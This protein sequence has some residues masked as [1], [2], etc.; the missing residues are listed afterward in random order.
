MLAKRP[1]W[2]VTI[3]LATLLL[4]LSSMAIFSSNA[5]AVSAVTPITNYTGP[6]LRLPWAS[7]S[8]GISQSYNCNPPDGDHTTGT[9]DQFALDFAFGSG[10]QVQLVAVFSGIVHYGTF[11]GIGYGNS[12]WISN[13]NWH[14]VYAHLGTSQTDT[15]FQAANGKPVTQGQNIAMSG[16]T[17]NV[18]P[19]GSGGAHLHFSLRYK[20]SGLSNQYDGDPVKP[21]PMS[22]YGVGQGGDGI[23]FGGDST[24]NT[25]PGSFNP[26]PTLPGGWW[27]SPPTPKDGTVITAGGT[28][29]V[30]VHAH[31]YT[32]SGLD[33]VNI[34]WLD[35]GQYGNQTWSKQT[36]TNAPNTTDSDFSASISVPFTNITNE[37]LASFDVYAKNGTSQLAPNGVHRYC[38]PQNSSCL[39]Y[40]TS[41]GR[42]GGSSDGATIY[43]ETN[44]NGTFETFTYSSNTT[45]IYLDQMAGRNKSFQFTG[46]YVGKYSAVMY[47]DANCG[48]Y[49]ARY[50]NPS[51]D[52]GSG[53]YNQFGSMRLEK[54][55]D[56]SCTANP[57]TDNG[58]IIY[59]DSNFGTGGGCKLITDNVPDLGTLQFTRITSIQFVGN[60]INHKKATFYKD[61]N[62]GTSC[63]VYTV[64]QSDLRECAQ[65]DIVSV[66]IED[67]TPPAQQAQNIASVATLDHQGASNAVDDNLSTEWISGHQVP[68]A[69]L[70]ASPVTVQK[71]V[72][73]D[74]NQSSSDNN[75]INKIQLVF[76]DGTVINDIDMTSGGP[77]C[78]DVTIPAKQVSWINVVPTDA[79]GNN[80]YRDIQIW[81]TGGS[82]VSQNNCV[83]KYS[84]TPVQGAGPAPLVPVPTP[85]PTPTLTPTATSTPI[86]GTQ[87]LSSPWRLTGNNGAAEQDTTI[88]ANTLSGMT[89]LQV[90][91]DLH[92]TTFVTSDDGASIVFVQGG[93]W[94][95]MN[96]VVNG[97]NNGSSGSQTLTVP[98]SA[99]HLFNNAGTLL[100]ITQSVSNLHTRFWNSGSFAVDITSIILMPSNGNLTPTPTPTPTATPSPTPT[101]S[102]TTGC[103]T[104]WTCADIGNPNVTGSQSF[105]NGTWTLQGAGVDIWDA[106]D[107]FH[108]VWQ[109]LSGD[110][111]VSTQVLSQTNTGGWAKAGIMLRQNTSTDSA[112]YLIAL[113]PG[114]GIT[115]QYR[116]DQGASAQMN[117]DFSG[118][119]PVYLQVTRSG[120]T[121]TAATSMDGITW[122]TVANSSTTLNVSGALLAGLEVD[123][124]DVNTAS[125][126]T[127]NN[128]SITP[129]TPATDCPT[130][131]NCTDIGSP[132]LAGSQSL[133]NGTLTVQ[134]AG[135]DIWGTSDQFH[136]VWQTLPADG[137]VSTQ[138]I[139][140]TNTADWAK[141]GVMLRQSTDAD[142]AY[143]AI[144]ITPGNGIVVQYRA[145]QG[146]SAANLTQISGTPPKYI[147]ATRSG[148][149]I[150][151]YTSDDGVSWTAIDG[152]TVTI[153][154]SGSL[155]AG[156]A[157]TSHAASLCTVS[158]DTVKVE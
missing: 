85:S 116:T 137:S 16:W 43:S 136:Y 86:Q 55:N 144:E 67:Y 139:S 97:A 46:N 123:S 27:T 155:L 75:Q 120:T 48:T 36:Q 8:Y 148:N 158:F 89:H 39:P 154:W 40:T 44:F 1:G 131:W 7:G 38:L 30:A 54:I 102:P 99:F 149:T 2:R 45:C 88:P 94:Y 83:M 135:G 133:D 51:P 32:G 122:N 117:A 59:R 60:F 118:S 33:H 126:V 53:L 153:N 57:S 21:E 107:Q 115:V 31:D 18:V 37:L 125:T 87:L 124:T 114:N 76:S 152:S 29:N 128:V 15:G 119:A 84:L 69:L 127:F 82:V 104:S 157:V 68:L 14:A 17:G 146:D 130:S 42:G 138:I 91:F 49:L 6:G 63:A 52:I 112:F 74:R 111:S 73:F 58:I 110:G 70:Y 80:G 156:L 4:A 50:G 134:G 79:S 129:T 150:T 100:D 65:I 72:V 5:K 24:C 105:T 71:I 113:T 121:F 62:Y 143:Y 106:A 26:V 11:D 141:G 64:N 90:T 25:R 47:H 95:C 92:G 142:A 3:L 103:P 12:L 109:S 10:H 77:R 13:G 81:D 20:T 23:S 78:A 56:T 34:T 98:L 41:G 93:Q 147:K 108:Y 9:K 101:P 96:V 19:S 61:A 140:Q 22:G 66:K 132:N 151:A 28:L 145:N 35:T